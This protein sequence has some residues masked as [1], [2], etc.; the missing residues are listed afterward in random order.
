MSDKNDAK[1]VFIF[2]APSGCG[3]TSLARALI[4]KRDDLSLSVSHTTRVIRPAEVHRRDYYF[5]ST[6]KFELMI[7]EG[8]FLEYAQ[9][10]DYLYGTA[11]SE[12]D[13]LN[14]AG[15][16]AILD[17][18]WQ[19]ARQVRQRKSDVI[20]IFIMPPSLE[21]LERRLQA[22]GQ[23]SQAVIDRRMQDAIN[24][25]SHRDEYDHI[26]VNDDFD[27]SLLELETIFETNS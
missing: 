26:I 21:S 20:S 4:A 17:I 6:S 12:T 14:A 23:D 5:V 18:D 13:R 1:R 3:K 25:M 15:K 19:G 2:S 24:E 10:F 9:V 11:K 27:Q 22:R 8:Q 16:H 7:D